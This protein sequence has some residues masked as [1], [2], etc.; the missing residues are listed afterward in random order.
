[1][2]F[3]AWGLGTLVVLWVMITFIDR[4]YIKKIF[5]CDDGSDIDWAAEFD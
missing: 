4:Y 3:L 5:S 1:M 2:E